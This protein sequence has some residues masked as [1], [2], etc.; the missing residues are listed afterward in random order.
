MSIESE[1]DLRGLLRAG[2][3]VARAIAVMRAAVRPGMSTAELD[4]VGAE[5]FRRHGAR[6]APWLAY[7]FPGTNC[8]SLNDEAVH[9]VPAPDRLIR[10]GDLVKIDVTAELDGYMADACVTVEA[11]TQTPEK[12]RLI[13]AAR[14]ALALGIEAATAGQPVTAIGAAVQR[15]VHR[16]GFSVLEPL[17]GHGIGRT[18][19]EPPEVPNY[20]DPRNEALLTDGLVVTVE[21]IIAAGR[22]TE[23]QHPRADGWTLPTADGSL[24]AHEEHTI[25][26]RR[27][28][29]I[30]VTAAT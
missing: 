22:S 17:T 29:P 1:A 20:P 21:P 6:S 30:V 16:H 18:I 10:R 27:G 2:R 13:G 25:V 14:S 7:R 24:S 26:V 9:G 8:I 12:Q 5:V 15:E 11:E 19:H 28:R 23:V 3:V 4:A